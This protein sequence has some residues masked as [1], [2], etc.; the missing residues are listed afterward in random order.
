M[1]AVAG[2]DYSTKAVHGAIVA[3][4]QLAFVKEYDL[5]DA[6]VTHRVPIKRMLADLKARGVE[7]IYMEQPF[8]IP[9]RI[10]KVTQKL[11]QGS[12]VNTLKLHKVATEVETL[13]GEAGLPV[14][15]VAPA[16]WKSE[17][18][19]GVPGET[20]KAKSIWFVQRV[21]NLQTRDD[22][23]ADAICL[24]TYGEALARYKGLIPP[25]L[26]VL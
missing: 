19:T 21:W 1:T 6:S 24:A 25:A 23:K 20:T 7:R 10:D 4:K 3:D 2:V 8:F 9:A 12:N 16:T 22:N 15:Y 14:T 13:A 26:E 11:K 17:I 18:L 5:G